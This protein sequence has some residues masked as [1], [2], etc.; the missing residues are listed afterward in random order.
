MRRLLYVSPSGICTFP[1]LHGFAPSC[2]GSRVTA[3]FAFFL[4]LFLEFGNDS[5]YGGK[6]FAFAGG[7][8][9]LQGVLEVDGRG[10]G[11]QGIEH[12]GTSGDFFVVLEF[13]VNESDGFGEARLCLVEPALVPIDVTE[14]QQQYSGL[15]CALRG[16]GTSGFVGTDG[17]QRVALGH[18]DVSDGIVHLV[19]VVL[20]VV[21]L[22]HPF[23]PLDH[24]FC[25]RC[26][27]DGFGLQ[28]ACMEGH[29]VRRAI[30]NALSQS[31]VG[32][33]LAVESHIG[34]GKE[35]IEACPACFPFFALDGAFQVG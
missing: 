2:F 13:L 27:S 19:K 29:V 23:Q 5:V 8:K 34:L 11:N 32:F 4:L 20:V 30:R 3:G 33:L 18:M 6:A 10:G 12:L 17:R 16:F 14:A 35:V 25:V 22:C 15:Q 21:A 26:G 7:S 9:P 1:L 31:L 24:G 28:Y